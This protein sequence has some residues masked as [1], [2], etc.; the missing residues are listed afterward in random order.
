M[1][2]RV[3]QAWKSHNSDSEH[4]LIEKTND[5]IVEEENRH[6][7]RITRGEEDDRSEQ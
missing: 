7:I 2:R 6:S 3:F 1:N 4:V 5:D